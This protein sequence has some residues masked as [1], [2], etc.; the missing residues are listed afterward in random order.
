MFKHSA[1]IVS[2]VTHKF[3]VLYLTHFSLYLDSSKF[4]KL[5]NAQNFVWT[6]KFA[7][8]AIIWVDM[9]C[10]SYTLS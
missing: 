8:V 4:A 6:F 5:F 9:N 7:L 10:F 3:Y 1:T 2:M